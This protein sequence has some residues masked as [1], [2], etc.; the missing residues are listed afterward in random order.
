MV[1]KVPYEGRASHRVVTLG[2]SWEVGQQGLKVQGWVGS[3]DPLPRSGEGQGSACLPGGSLLCL[4]PVSFKNEKVGTDADPPGAFPPAGRVLGAEPGRGSWKE[5]GG[6]TAS[7]P[8][9]CC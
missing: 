3:Q 1:L 4:L 7:G 5:E 9:A 6:A 8:A 2:A